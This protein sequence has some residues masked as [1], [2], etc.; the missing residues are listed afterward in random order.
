[1]KQE[2]V[3]SQEE[4]LYEKY[5]ITE[6]NG[7]SNSDQSFQCAYVV[8]RSMQG[9][10][11][12]MQCFQFAKELA[13]TMPEETNKMFFH[14]WLRFE[15]PPAPTS[16][17]WKHQIYSECSRFTRKVVI[18]LFA[19]AIIIAAFYLMVLFKNLNDEL[20]LDAGINVKC[21]KKT[22]TVEDV[23]NDQDKPIKQRQGFRHCWC[24]KYK[25]DNGGIEGSWDELKEV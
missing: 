11:K 3:K 12:A 15:H 19:F 13:K 23:L 25:L 24:V 2:Y 14:R 9:K 10:E 21:S 7:R 6:T 22:P 16:M 5:E 18:W 8:F 17:I 4:K 20:T 1:M